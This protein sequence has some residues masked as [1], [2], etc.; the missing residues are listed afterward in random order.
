MPT[1]PGRTAPGGARGQTGSDERG[2]EAQLSQFGPC[3]AGGAIASF[4]LEFLNIFALTVEEVGLT[5][6]VQHDIDTGDALPIK[7]RPHRLP[8]AHQAAADCAIEE[9]LRAGTIEPL[10]K[11][12]SKMR[13]CV[14]YR[15]LNSVTK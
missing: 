11:R 5:N 3:T 9:M 12:S 10:K 14:D 15:P 1:C 8:L 6:L 7:T 4:F 2:M 13:F